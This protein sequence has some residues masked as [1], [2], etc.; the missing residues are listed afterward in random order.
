MQHPYQN[1][2][3]SPFCRVSVL[4]RWQ[5]VALVAITDRY[6]LVSPTPA[7]SGSRLDPTPSSRSALPMCLCHGQAHFIAAA[8]LSLGSEEAWQPRSFRASVSLLIPVT[9]LQ[10]VSDPCLVLCSRSLPSA[11]ISSSSFPSPVSCH[12][13]SC[14]ISLSLFPLLPYSCNYSSCVSCVLYPVRLS[15][16]V[17]SNAGR[18]H[19]ADPPSRFRRHR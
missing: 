6:Y 8:D 7:K 11:P 4:V 1:P 14:F 12:P 10:P 5:T 17:R 2:P 16:A 18:F 9:V 3:A 15:V 19:V 13:C